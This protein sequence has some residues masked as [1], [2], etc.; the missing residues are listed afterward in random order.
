[1]GNPRADFVPIVDRA[2]LH[3]PEGQRVIAMLVV[4][5][6]QKEFDAPAGSPLGPNGAKLPEVPVFSKFEYSLRAGILR[7]LK[8]TKRLE[9]PVSMTLNGSVC[10]FYPRVLEA[11]VEA[12]WDA[13]AHD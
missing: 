2:P 7:M 1:M 12:G 3:L 9:I 4:N 11:C 13:V 5:V 6:E 10:D 8:V